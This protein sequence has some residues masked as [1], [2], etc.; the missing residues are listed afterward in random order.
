MKNHAQKQVKKSSIR[1]KISA[2]YAFGFI[3][4][5]LFALFI[6]TNLLLIEKQIELYSTI[7][8]FLDVILEA[9]RF[10]KNYFLYHDKD[11]INR[12]LSFVSIAQRIVEDDIESHKQGWLVRVGELWLHPFEESPTQSGQQPVDPGQILR[13]LKEYASLLTQTQSEPEPTPT[14]QSAI[15]DKGQILSE[16]AERLNKLEFQHIQALFKA[17][18]W[19]LVFLIVTFFIF[20]LV[21]ARFMVQ[22]VTNPLR[23]LEESMNRISSGNITPL[24]LAVADD[25]MRSMHEAFNRMIR[26]LFEHRREIV[27]SE[28]LASLGTMLAGIAHEI[29]NPLSNIS[30]SAEILHAEMAEPDI[31]YKKMLAEQ[32][33]SATDRAR[34]IIKTVL[35]FS[36]DRSSDKSRTNLLSAIQGALLLMRGELDDNL[37][38]DIKIAS[39]H[40]VLA[41]KQQLQQVFINL[42]KNSAEA[43]ESSPGDKHIAISSRDGHDGFLEV[44][45]T[46]SGPGLPAGC[47]QQIFDPFFTTK[48]PGKGTGLGLFVTY[49]IIEE[50][51]GVI[52][53]ESEPEQGATFRIKIPGGEESHG[54]PPTHSDRR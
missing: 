43:M 9:R 38:V 20:T 50:H 14:L 12:S 54:C 22:S 16:I 34:D 29:N 11:D 10:E 6:F 48:E 18:K 47:S 13:L 19:I 45:L 33:V 7:S 17:I 1:K 42:L 28:K 3:S 41:N 46:D 30:T 52:R 32:I 5:V 49:Q 23:S 37:V 31:T 25:E 39:D 51:G 35:D 27:R 4:I 8:R 21:V 15:R 24:P 40:H 53:A 26:E 36:R 2:G 44:T